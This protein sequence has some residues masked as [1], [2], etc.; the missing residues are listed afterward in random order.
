MTVTSAPQAKAP[1]RRKRGGTPELYDFR[2]PMTLARE[3][4]RVLEMAF[5]TF[6][7]QWGTLLTART[8]VVAA[9]T[10]DSVELRSYDEFVRALPA[11]TLMILCQVEQNRSTAVLQVPVETGMIWIDY[12]LGGPGRPLADPERE[13]TEIEWSLLGDLVQHALHD[14]SYAFS[15]VTP[16][17][18]HA[19][20]VQYSP[21]F[22]QAAAAS[23]PVVVATFEVDLGGRTSRT[24]LMI[25]AEV[26]LVPLRAG[27]A[28]DSRSG[29]E[30]R[31]HRAALAALADQV[32]E[33]PVDVR[34]RF[35]P[36]TIT[37]GAVEA[38]RL[39]DI[40]SLRHRADHPLDVVVD[41]VPLARAALGSNR[42]RLACMVV[43]SEE[44]RP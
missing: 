32:R 23:E 30:L 26:L 1:A 42:N 20:S 44:N 22:V 9:I 11:T 21:Q 39:G 35:S 15:A 31:E 28:A 7:R 17:D 43:T 6:A 13:L 24:E 25:P 12:L 37:S 14:L 3:H 34:V 29:D 16:L 27:E 19:K 33:V 4:G 36:L 41:D 2:R 38:L 8:R 5:E 10:L 40:V 18:L